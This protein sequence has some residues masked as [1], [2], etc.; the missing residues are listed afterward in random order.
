MAEKYPQ[1]R[2]LTTGA[3]K[4]P[5]VARNLGASRAVAEY[6]VFVDDDVVPETGTLYRLW[7]CVQQTQGVCAWVGQI[8]PDSSVPDNCYLH[9]AYSNVA[10]SDTKDNVD[11]FS[12]W[13]FCTSLACVRS[14]DF[15]ATGGFDERFTRPGYEDVELGYRLQRNGVNLMLCPEAVGKHQRRMDRAW[16]IRRCETVGGLLRKMHELHP[17]TRRP[18]H[19]FLQKAKWAAPG[20]KACWWALSKSLGCIEAMPMA[21]SIPLLRLAHAGGLAAGYAR[22][23]A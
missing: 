13:H 15:A 4:G 17:E 19:V 14:C 6:L 12:Y 3:K 2:I 18:I 1:V 22:K 23:N 11:A 10:H 8:I 9:L 16:F 21:L 7:V 20:F 5:A